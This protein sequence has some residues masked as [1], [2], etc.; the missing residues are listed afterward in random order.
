MEEILI[1]VR[2]GVVQNIVATREILVHLFDYD[3][4]EE[5]SFHA[6]VT[7]LSQEDL[8]CYLDQILKDNEG[9][10]F[11]PMIIKDGY[12][13]WKDSTGYWGV[14]KEGEEINHCAYASLDAVLK[15]KGVVL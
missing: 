12:V 6:E 15:Q 11:T 1:E 14:T 4:I 13:F 5:T 8:A 7:I 10:T 9:V 2:G 3:N